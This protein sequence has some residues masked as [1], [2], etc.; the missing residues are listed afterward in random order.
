MTAKCDFCSQAD[1]EWVYPALPFDMKEEDWG[2]RGGWA[3]CED[4]SALIERGAQR[5]LAQKSLNSTPAIA[6]VA[7]VLGH[8]LTRDERRALRAK[9]EALH[10]R[11]YR[12]RLGPRRAFG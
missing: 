2:S 1:P 7:A 8:T 5:Q 12:S 9:V 10:A 4:C 6:Q 3:A 11:F